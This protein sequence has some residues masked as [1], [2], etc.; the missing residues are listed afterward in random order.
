VGERNAIAAGGSDD[1]RRAGF[2][3]VGV[4]MVSSGRRRAILCGVIAAIA[5]MAG[6]GRPPLWEPDEGR[7]AE[8]PREMIVS[9]DYVT[10][11][12]DWVRYFEKPPLVYWTTAIAM[13]ALGANEFGARLPAAI[14]SA[15]EVAITEAIAEAMFG[16]ASGVLAAMALALS[17]LFFGFARFATIDPALAFFVTAGLGCYFA[18]ARSPSFRAGAGRRWMILAAMALAFGTLTKGP[19]ALVLGGGIGAVHL[20]AERRLRDIAAIPWLMLVAVGGLIVIPWFAA[21]AIQNPGFLSF[22]LVHEHLERYLSSTEHDWGPYFLFVVAI[23]GTWPWIYFAPAGVLAIRRDRTADTAMRQSALRFLLIWAGFVLMFFSIPRS[24]L[25]SYVLPGLPPLA[26][27][28][29][30]GLDALRALRPE[31]RR[32]RISTL[33]GICAAIALG[34]VI[35]V[36]FAG[37]RLGPGLGADAIGVAIGPLIGAALAL[38]AIRIGYGG[39]IAIAAIV[40]GTMVAFGAAMKARTDMISRNTYRNLA[41]AIRPYLAPGCTLASYVHFEQTIPFYTRH[42]EALVGYRGELAPFGDSADAAASFIRNGAAMAVMWGT[43]GGCF[44][45]V[46]DRRDLARVVPILNPAPAV[47]GCEGKKVALYNRA[48][49]LAHSGCKGLMLPEPPRFDEKNSSAR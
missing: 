18:A 21:A 19:V 38:A 44:V 8:I 11:R 34:T 35:A 49:M 45:L 12:D 31:F 5:Y 48:A 36:G 41:L 3:T 43:P 2:R 40:L 42:R 29:G 9:G 4:R 37:Q 14:F 16:A 17:P 15:G 10:P 22:F 23:A 24:K 30:R 33:A 39:G 6:L 27:L 28:A 20:M 46:I 47:I 13:K 26:I 32:Q 7:Y 25:G 1:G